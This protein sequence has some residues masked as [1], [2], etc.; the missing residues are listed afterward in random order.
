MSKPLFFLVAGPNGAGKSTFT[1]DYRR[2][3]PFLTVID[4]DAIAKEFSGSYASMEKVATQA[5]RET[6]KLIR[7][8]IDARNSF[9]VES[10]ISGS[11]YLKYA[12]RAKD[13]G[14]RTI[15]IYI[16]LDSAVLSAQRV[17]DRV[18]KGGHDIPEEDIIRRYPKSLKNL[19]PYIDVFDVAHIYDNSVTRQWVAGYRHGVISKKSQL[20]P[21]WLNNLLYIESASK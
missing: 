8:Y 5:G 3:Y 17:Q 19:K 2:H 1:S 6:I 7:E 20:V 18:A 15:L 10:T 13:A 14:Y 16:A 9:L 4:P 12:Q 11:L 21:K